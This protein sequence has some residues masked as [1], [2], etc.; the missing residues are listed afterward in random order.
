MLLALRTLTR[1]EKEE[2]HSALDSP[3]TR[4]VDNLVPN[5]RAIVARDEVRATRASYRI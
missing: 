4:F 5:L 3:G 2:W 1:F